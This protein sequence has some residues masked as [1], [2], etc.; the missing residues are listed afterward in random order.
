VAPLQQDDV[1]AVALELAHLLRWGPLAGGSSFQPVAS[2][3]T[4]RLRL[5]RLLLL[6]LMRRRVLLHLLSATFLPSWRQLS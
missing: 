1:I 4:L 6:L 3:C 2:A 5:L